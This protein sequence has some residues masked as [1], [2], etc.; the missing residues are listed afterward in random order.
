[1]CAVDSERKCTKFRPKPAWMKLTTKKFG[2]S[3]VRTPCSEW[4]PSCQRSLSRCPPRPTGIEAE[5]ADEP[6]RDLEPGREDEQVERVL[7]AVDHRTGRRHLAHTST[8]GVDEV[9]VREVERLEV[10][11]VEAQPLA[12]LAVPGL[13]LLRGRRVLDDLVDSAAERLH[14]L[15]VDRLELGPLLF[16]RGDALR[17]DPHRR[18]PPVVHHV[19]VGQVAGD[20]LGEVAGALASATPAAASGTTSRRWAAGRAHRPPRAC[21]GRRRP[22]WRRGRAAAPTAPRSRRCR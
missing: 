4:V 22:P 17:V 18:G 19:A 7:H 6:G 16:G 11:V 8:V 15:E 3:A 2:K 21:A 20:D 14:H 1:M 5:P 13:E 12:V 10:L 9:H